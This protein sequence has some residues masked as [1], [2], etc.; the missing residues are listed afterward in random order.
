MSKG[1]LEAFSDG[2]LA[3]VITIMVLEL[4][5][6][7]EPGLDAVRPLVPAL[8]AYVL[9]FVYVGIYW[10]NHHHLFQ[11][12]RQPCRVRSQTARGP[13][14]AQYPA[15][16][17]KGR[18][19]AFSDG[20]LAIVITIM[21]L[22]LRPP[23]GTTFEDLFSLWPQ[24]LAYAMSFAYIA[25]YWVNHHHLFQAVRTVSARV[26]WAN[27]LLLFALSLVPF[28]TA[29]MGEHEFGPNTVAISNIVLLLPAFSYFL[30]VRA[31]LATPGQS[32]TLAEA[33]SDNRKGQLSLFAY[34]LALAISLFLPWV[35][36]AIDVFVA[37]TWIVPDRRIE[38]RLSEPN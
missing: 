25:I 21:V 32:S 4:K 20:V 33:L 37:A 8:L 30:L 23:E 12:A 11:A 28:A 16:V 24:F 3:I 29:W 34:L 17:S 26:L 36:V 10:N 13:G 1:R 7:H 18:L 27:I 38:R 2:V 15:L 6:P 19:E 14:L 35:A 22:E 5:A 31:L 9:S